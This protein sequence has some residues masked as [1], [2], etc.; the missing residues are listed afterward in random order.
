MTVVSFGLS[1]DPAVGASTRFPI[2]SVTVR[3][4][5]PFSPLFAYPFLTNNG[6]WTVTSQATFSVSQGRQ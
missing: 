2:G 5:V 1:T 4:T 6:V 3:A